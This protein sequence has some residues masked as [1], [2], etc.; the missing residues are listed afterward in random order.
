[1][2]CRT[3]LSRTKGDGIVPTEEDN[4]PTISEHISFAIGHLTDLV[5]K[6]SYVISNIMMM[7]SQEFCEKKIFKF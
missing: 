2:L 7:V 1:M 3:N 4:Q 6:H 5:C